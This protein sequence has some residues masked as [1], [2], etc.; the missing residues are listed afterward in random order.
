MNPLYTSVRRETKRALTVLGAILCLLIPADFAKADYSGNGAENGATDMGGGHPSTPGPDT[1]NAAVWLNSS[2]FGAFAR[3]QGH[4]ST[5]IGASTIVTGN[6]STA[7]GFSAGAR[8][9]NATAV[10]ARAFA[11]E[12]S[13]AVGQFARAD[14]LNSTAVGHSACAVEYSATALGRDAFARQEAT[15]LGAFARADDYSIALGARA[16]ANGRG[17]AVAIGTGSNATG[18]DAIAIGRNVLATGGQIRIGNSSVR[19]VRIGAYDLSELSGITGDGISADAVGDIITNAA[20]EGG[21]IDRA[22]DRALRVETESRANADN[23]LRADLGT[24]TDMR[25][26]N[27][28]AHARI[29]YIQDVIGSANSAELMA[30]RV[31]EAVSAVDPVMPDEE[32]QLSIKINAETG[33]IILTGDSVRAQV[34][35]LV[36]A[37]SRSNSPLVDAEG[38][39]VNTSLGEFNELDPGQVSGNQRLTYLFRAL[40]GDPSVASPG[41]N[42]IDSNTPH[43]DSIVGRIQQGVLRS[44]ADVAADRDTNG[45]LAGNGGYRAA[46]TIGSGRM[47]A[48]NTEADRQ[49]VV[50]DTNVDGTV[51]LSTLPFSTLSGLD[52]RVEGLEKDLSAGIAM[53]MAMQSSLLPGERMSVSLGSATYNKEYAA[54]LSLGLRINKRWRF[55]TGVGWGSS[56]TKLG[57]RFGATYG[58]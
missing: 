4:D 27:G 10:G 52:R 55:N 2:A 15:A 18:T 3:T 38:N 44:E 9:N 57:G 21:T 14:G 30:W 8:G 32:G 50:Q 40:Y 33:E 48:P 58:W 39:P 25:N 7:I 22:I 28:S 26:S 29:N 35:S 47:D 20:T 13:T 49:L 6:S 11:K 17:G 36:A 53:S 31:N 5:A 19:N 41:D 43:A 34:A 16:F 51:R 54:A 23:A 37:L 42:D 12:N 46:P 24:Q 1:T 45:G 56:G